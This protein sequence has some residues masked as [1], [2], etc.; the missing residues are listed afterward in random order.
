MAAPDVLLPENPYV[1]L[2]F[3][4]GTD[5]TALVDESCEEGELAGLNELLQEDGNLSSSYQQLCQAVHSGEQQWTANYYMANNT[6]EPQAKKDSQRAS[7]SYQ[8]ERSMKERA[9]RGKTVNMAME[10][11]GLGQQL[12]VQGNPVDPTVQQSGQIP[13]SQAQNWGAPLAVFAAAFQPSWIGGEAFLLRQVEGQAPLK[14]IEG[15]WLKTE[16][17]RAMLQAEVS[18]LL[19]N[20]SLVPADEGSRATNALTLASS[21]GNSYPERVP[22]RP[23][24]SEARYRP[25]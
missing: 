1:R 9:V 25:P 7:V 13:Q 23:P 14:Q 10:K 8:Q 24:Q 16:A 18:D 5:G 6:Q 20:A 3:R 2:R 15:V 4:V 11:A 22:W 21:R 17:F 12:A 19:P